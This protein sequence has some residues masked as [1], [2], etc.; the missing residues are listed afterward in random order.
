MATTQAL[1]T[2][3][4]DALAVPLSC[5]PAESLVAFS[6]ALVRLRARFDALV[7]AAVVAVGSSAEA[8]GDTG[9]GRPRRPADVIAARTGADPKP[10]ASQS[11]LSG[12]LESFPLFRAA[13]AAGDLTTDHVRA[14]RRMDNARTRIA[15][16]DAQAYLVEAAQRCTWSEFVRVTRYWVLAA[17][18]DGP[19]P[20]DRVAG[21][22]CRISKR[23][24]GSVTARLELDP[25]AGEAVATAIGHAERRLFRSDS[26][27][28]SDR[29]AAQRRADAATE[30]ITAGHVG[31]AGGP[32]RPAPPLVHLVLSAKVAEQLVAGEDPCTDPD[33]VDGRCELVDGT[34]IHPRSAAAVTAVA[35]LH[36]LILGAR[37]QPL[38][39]GRAVRTFPAQLKQA[40]LVAARGRCQ[41]RG[42]DAPLPW[43]QADHV[44]PWYRDGPT[45][46]SN[47]QILCD[48][49]N[50]AKGSRP[51]GDST[52]QGTPDRPSGDGP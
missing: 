47:G 9:V 13:H 5:Q 8:A 25:I 14:V 43:L 51:P 34:P 39:L 12:W 38:D 24:D 22:S 52:E 50:K 44:Q 48:P 19:E 20:Q 1:G 41:I 29:T 15:L 10:L 21:R 27:S 49:H 45:A 37:S 3:L 6:T 42:C 32:G 23:A 2:A 30:L 33:D 46:T 36:R 26:E 11:R 28:G 18:P 17:D 40:L 31:T 4:D 16:L 7:G 35:T